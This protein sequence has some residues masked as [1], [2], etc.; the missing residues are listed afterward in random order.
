[1]SYSKDLRKRAIDFVIEE[2]HE[3][4]KQ[5]IWCTVQHNERMGNLKKQEK[6]LPSQFVEPSKV[7]LSE[8]YQQVLEYPDRFQYEHAHWSNSISH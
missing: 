3:K 2:K 5:N 4:Y 7:N 8:L 1:M 6:Y